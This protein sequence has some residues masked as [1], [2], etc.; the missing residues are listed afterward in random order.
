MQEYASSGEQTTSC[1]KTTLTRQEIT[2]YDEDSV[3]DNVF[4]LI[5]MYSN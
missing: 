4:T 5:P 2:S 3:G 1:W